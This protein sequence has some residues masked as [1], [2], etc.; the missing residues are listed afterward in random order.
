MLPE[1]QAVASNLARLLLSVRLGLAIIPEHSVKR[2]MEGMAEVIKFLKI[3]GNSNR[4]V[5]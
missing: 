4:K 1:F 5:K 3:V 2:A